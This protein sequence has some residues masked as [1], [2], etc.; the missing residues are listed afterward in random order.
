MAS[1]VLVLVGTMIGGA[2]AL[3]GTLL[4]ARRA[5]REFQLR[6]EQERRTSIRGAVMAF[7]EV[8]Q[9]LEEALEDRFIEGKDVE[10]QRTLLHRMWLAQK[11][12]D[13]DG[14][15]QLREASIDFALALHRVVWDGLREGTSLYEALK[16]ERNAFL[17]AARGDLRGA[18]INP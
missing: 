6:Q 10:S 8:V 11:R 2:L 5:D 15:E 12:L 18:P 3:T 14:S 16:T 13:I 7:L 4:T 9:A 1:A 17:A